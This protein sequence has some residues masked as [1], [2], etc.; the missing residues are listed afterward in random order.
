MGTP[1]P[2]ALS[3]VFLDPKTPT[4]PE[5]PK[6]ILNSLQQLLT[7]TVQ[8]SVALPVIALIGS[9]IGPIGPLEPTGGV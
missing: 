8:A 3:P 4:A 6:A 9:L 2:Q 1:T 7:A 5:H